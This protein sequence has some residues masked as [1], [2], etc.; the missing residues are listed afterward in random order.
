MA[1]P[2]STD[3]R[4]R[5]VAAV[6]DGDTRQEAADRLGVSVRTVYSLLRLRRDTGSVVPRP[7]A[8]GFPSAV[9]QPAADRLRALVAARPDAT[10]AEFCRDLAAAGGPAIGASRMCQVLAALGLRRK[11]RS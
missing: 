9:D 1:E 11:K 10:L 8:G 3:L 7:H 4:E 2:Y 6:D 5:I